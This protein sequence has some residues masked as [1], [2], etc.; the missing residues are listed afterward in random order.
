MTDDI[1]NLIIEHLRHIRGRVDRIAEDMGDMKHRMS[2]LESAMVLVKRE[3]SA[4]DETDVRHQV[5]LDRLMDR[6]ERI[7]RRLELSGS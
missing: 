3:V 5:S 1:D 6:I 4:G 2:S 7:E